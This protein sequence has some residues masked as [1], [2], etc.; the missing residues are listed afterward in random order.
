MINVKIGYVKWLILVV[1]MLSFLF[2]SIFFKH[3]ETTEEKTQEVEEEQL[4]LLGTTVT[5][6]D[7]DF[8]LTEYRIENGFWYDNSLEVIGNWVWH[9]APPGKKYLRV[10]AIGKNKVDELRRLPGD[11]NICLL[12]NGERIE[13]I[14][15]VYFIEN[16]FIGGQSWTVGTRSGWFTFEI[17]E[18][19]RMEKC[20]VEVT[21]DGENKAIWLC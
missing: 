7:I 9:E 3:E 14:F 2:G 16:M 6:G 1:I 5:W 20:R 12:Y 8:T 21:F 18:G 13:E 10:H 11:K 15:W 17:P 4:L 19:M